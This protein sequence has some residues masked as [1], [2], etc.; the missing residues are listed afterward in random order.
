M[1]F[2][3]LFNLP[4]PIF[5][6]SIPCIKIQKKLTLYR[7]RNLAIK[8]ARGKYISFLDVDDMWEKEKIESQISFL[9]KNREFTIV[10]S[11]YY[12]LKEKMKKKYIKFKK[13]LKSG[14]ITQDLLNEYSI[15]ILTV[16]FDSK[17]IKKDFFDKRYNIIGDFDCFLKLSLKYKIAYLNKPLASYRI[18]DKNYSMKN[19][20]EYVDELKIWMKNNARF[21]SN[22]SFLNLNIYLIKLRIKVLL[23]YCMG[24]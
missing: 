13:E 1:A 23:K 21:F 15:G 17:I 11:N 9:K 18:H 16:F 4:K 12:V 19:L 24:V 8:Q 3:F 5:L 20:N 6:H 2:C 10:Y 14:F 7:A 22:F